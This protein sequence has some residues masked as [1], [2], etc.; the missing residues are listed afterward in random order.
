MGHQDK[1]V[2]F[3]PSIIKNDGKNKNYIY[4]YRVRQN[5]LTHL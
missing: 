5:D 4:I 3:L 1:L 2:E